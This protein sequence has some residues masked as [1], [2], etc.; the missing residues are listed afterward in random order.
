MCMKDKQRDQGV[1]KLIDISDCTLK[2]PTSILGFE[3]TGGGSWEKWDRY[4]TIDGMKTYHIGNI[5][6]TCAFFFVRME[7]TNQSINAEGVSSRLEVGI[8]SLKDPVVKD[9]KSIFPSDSYHI[10]LLEVNPVLVNPASPMDYFNTE[11]VELWGL[12][13][14]S[15]TRTE[16]YRSGSFTFGRKNGFYEFLIPLFPHTSLNNETIESYLRLISEQTLPTAFSISVLDVKG[17]AVWEG[18]KKIERHW[19]LSHYLL[20]GHHKVYAAAKLGKPLKLVSFLSKTHG[21]SQVEEQRQLIK[22]LKRS[23]NN[24]I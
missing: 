24:W 12:D 14:F 20:D 4:L 17:P 7:G 5:C 22:E 9:I 23:F 10:L 15:N 18:E 21:K 2:N 19:C 13:S 8:D 1:T 6:D 16:Y 3:T 11:L